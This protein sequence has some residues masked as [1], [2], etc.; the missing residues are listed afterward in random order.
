[1]RL[2]QLGPIICIGKV[3]RGLAIRKEVN[4]VRRKLDRPGFED[5]GANANGSRGD[6]GDADQERVVRGRFEVLVRR[7]AL[8]P[9]LDDAASSALLG[10][11]GDKGDSTAKI[12]RALCAEERRGSSRAHARSALVRH[13]CQ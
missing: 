10:E 8:G 4:R 11:R 1:M 5:E 9:G 3:N 7:V 13:P 6:E 2:G 12:T